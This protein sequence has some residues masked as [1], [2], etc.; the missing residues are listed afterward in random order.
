MS[1]GGL[2]RPLCRS[3][4]IIGGVLQPRST[5]K[6]CW[7]EMLTEEHAK[8]LEQFLIR[9]LQPKLN[10]SGHEDFVEQLKKFKLSAIDA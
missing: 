2:S 10:R 6:L 3:H 1:V 7:N 9:N 8:L 5:D 4:H